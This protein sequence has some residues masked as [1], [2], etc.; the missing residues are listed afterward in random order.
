MGRIGHWMAVVWLSTGPPVEAL[1]SRS[2][3]EVFSTGT[4][5]GRVETP[6]AEPV[7][8]ARVSVLELD[9]STR[10]NARGSFEFLD[11]PAGTYQILVETELRAAA[12]ETVNVEGGEVAE[13]VLVAEGALMRVTEAIS[14][15][16]RADEMIGVADSAS[17]GVTG[18]RDLA[19]R[20]ILRPGDLLETVPG[21]VATQ[22]SGGGKANQYFVRGFNL[23]HGTDFRVTLDGVPVNMPSHGHGQGYLDL[24]FLIPELVEKVSY[25]KGPY[26]VEE[27]D[28]SGAG[29][30]RFTFFDRLD[31]AIVNVSG[32][33]F[34]YARALAAGSR[35]VGGGDLLAA[36]DFS[37][38]DGPWELPDD[39]E[40]LSALVR[41]TRRTTNGGW[42][43]SAQGY[44]GDWRSTDQIPLRAVE[45]GALSRFGFVDGSDGGK[46]SRYTLWGEY[47]RTGA[48]SLTNVQAY[49]LSYD[50]AL[51][52]N[53]TYRLGDPE[54]GDQFEQRDGRTVAGV[55]IKHSWLSDWAG[56]SLEN[57]AGF[58]L[59]SDWIDNGLFSTRERV[60]LS[61]TRKDDISQLGGGPYF[62]N[63]IR[64][65]DWLR[66]VAGVRADFYRVNVSSDNPLNSGG[67]SDGLASPKL[68]V[69]LGPWKETEIYGN[70]GGGFHSNDARGATIAVDP[71]T[72]VPVD[73]VD[74]L[75]RAWGFDLGVR[76]QAARGLHTAL[77]FFHLD[78]DSELLFIGDGGA[79]EASRPSRRLGVEWSNFYQP[80]DWLKLD[81]DAAFT[82]A[83]FN[84]DDPADRIP[85]AMETVIAAGASI[86]AWRGWSGSLRWRYFGAKPLIEDDS[87]RSDSSSFVT[88][89]VAY[90]LSRG[91]KLGLDVFNLFDSEA[92]DV[93]Y[94]YESRLPGE[95]V[96]VEDAHFHPLQSRSVRLF[97]DWRF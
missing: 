58:E 9:R 96:G 7:D 26:F 81:F 38:N 78:L 65:S 24:N 62:E 48:S 19:A 45:S 32:G 43:L 55:N 41:Y 16:G 27:G 93:D 3:G 2:Q 36:V 83:R 18:Q 49:V 72:G 69:V 25:R 97:L 44:D 20:A 56:R 73:P 35:R 34:G 5:R 21:L 42:R 47:W 39:F 22:H 95:A 94:F 91:V 85:G 13:L 23:D 10:T 46:S 90:D 14:V 61:T 79:T 75:V 67:R 29:A 74:P 86:D 31:E 84:D 63:R 40:K 59:R 11:V 52:S 50:L 1:A 15:T 76:T 53:F 4:L 60:R 30:A 6:S 68:S 89:R 64:W 66:T 37:H 54:N 70:F 8:A 80:L 28:F 12:V 77:T 88:A 87:V 51:F 17:E 57:V 71:T 92:N 82:R 33:N